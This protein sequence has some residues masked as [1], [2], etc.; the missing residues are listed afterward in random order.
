MSI[1]ISSE[2]FTAIVPLPVSVATVRDYYQLITVHVPALVIKALSQYIEQGRLAY[3]QYIESQMP[4]VMDYINTQ[5]PVVM[6]YIN[7]QVAVVMDYINTQVAVVIDYINTQAPI[8]LQYV[9]DYIQELQVVIP[10]LINDIQVK[11]PEYLAP[12]VEEIK[13]MMET[14]YEMA[15]KSAFAKLAEK[16]VKEIVELLLIKLNGV[17]K[18]YPDEIQAVKDFVI[19]Y[20]NICLDYATCVSNTVV[21]HPTV[22]KTIKY[23][24]ALTPEK[25][26]AD[27]K[28][29]VDFVMSALRQ[30]ETSLNDLLSVLPKDIPA[31][32]AVIPKDILQF[33]KMHIPNFFLTFLETVIMYIKQ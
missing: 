12:Y 23:I 13:A 14:S 28:T 5:V 17:E 26:Q 11:L 7:T 21:E 1:N 10:Q 31:L 16:K 22:Q 25:A 9:N 27:F 19:L 4:V 8:Y 32:I 24:Q 30:V 2:R 20:V 15:R 29:V 33:V 3:Y 18:S 6:D